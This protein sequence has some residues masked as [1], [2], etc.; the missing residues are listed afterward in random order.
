MSPRSRVL[1]QG[2]NISPA[3]GQHTMEGEVSTQRE[4]RF[5]VRTPHTL[6]HT[7]LILGNSISHIKRH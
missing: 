5:K 7:E 4:K 1:F 6:S 3:L 2:Q